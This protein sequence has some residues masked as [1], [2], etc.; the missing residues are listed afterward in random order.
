MGCIDEDIGDDVDDDTEQ[1]SSTSAALSQLYEIRS[2]M[3]NKCLDV[4]A[5]NN[6]NG[7]N[8]GMWD[9]WG[10]SNQHWYWNGSEIRSSMNNKCLDVL[11]LNNDNGAHVGMWDCW[12]GANQQWAV[13]PVW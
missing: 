13:W 3:N 1:T 9:C 6:D 7:A 12:G 8:A 5:F 10:G 2:F 4:L 11:G